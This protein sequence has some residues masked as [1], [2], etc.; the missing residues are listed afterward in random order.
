MADDSTRT[1][2]GRFDA[3]EVA[4]RVIEQLVQQYGIPRMDI[5]V[6]SAEDLNSAGKVA[7]GGDASHDGKV[8]DDAPLNGTL[9]VS[10]DVRLKDVDV[11]ERVFR[12][13]GASGVRAG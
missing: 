2:S 1:V 6:Q 10:A 4:D 11:V 12:E 13:A 5:F 3:R 8:R 7:S 9:E